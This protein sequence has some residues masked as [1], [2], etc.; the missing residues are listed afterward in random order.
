[1]KRTKRAFLVQLKGSAKHLFADI[2]S[3][4]YSWLA[5]HKAVRL[6]SFHF[7][8]EWLSQADRG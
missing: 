2:C 5:I 3:I 1:M 8:H 4:V 6:T 7:Y